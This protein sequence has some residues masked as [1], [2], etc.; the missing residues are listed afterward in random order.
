MITSLGVDTLKEEIMNRLNVTTE[1]GG[2]CH[3]QRSDVFDVAM[4]A[5]EPVNGYDLNY[6]EGLQ[7]EQRVAKHKFGFKTYVWVKRVSQRNESWDCF[8]YAL[9]ALLL[10][11]SGIHLEKMKRDTITITDDEA[12]TATTQHFGAQKMQTP[13]SEPTH[14][15]QSAEQQRRARFGAQNPPIW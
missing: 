13:I 7:A 12:K 6:F 10:P 1:G 2:F 9:A 3:F 14:R 11:Y 15:T 5:H 8:V 4:Q